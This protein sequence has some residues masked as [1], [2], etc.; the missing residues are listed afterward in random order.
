MKTFLLLCALVSIVLISACGSDRV[1][2]RLDRSKFGSS[3]ELTLERGPCFGVCPVYRITVS[4]DGKVIYEGREHVRVSGRVESS[5]GDGEIEQLILALNDADFLNL[6]DD[7]N[8][9]EVTDHSSATTL[10]KWD[11][12]QKRVLHYQGDL[13]APESLR[14]LEDRIDEILGSSNWTR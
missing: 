5:V 4:G 11:S 6:R 12:T 14:R 1:A 9:Q 7:Y 10:L 13:T 2:T 8:Q 3:A